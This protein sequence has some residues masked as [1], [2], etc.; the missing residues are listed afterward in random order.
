MSEQLSTYQ[1]WAEY[2]HAVGGTCSKDIA[3]TLAAG[4]FELPAMGR[5]YQLI[6]EYC[7]SCLDAMDDALFARL[8]SVDVHDAYGVFLVCSRFCDACENLLFFRKVDGIPVD[9]KNALEDDILRN[10]SGALGH[11][12]A[13]VPAAASDDAAYYLRCL[14]ERRCRKK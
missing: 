9:W 13:T 2:L 7:V 5:V 1:D 8:K 3:Q 6:C 14:Q 10:M 11:V 12:R 4:T